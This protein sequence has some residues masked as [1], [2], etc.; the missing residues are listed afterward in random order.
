M[1]VGVDPVI[2]VGGVEAQEV[3]PLDEGDAP[4]VNEAAHVPDLDAEAVGDLGD[5]EQS[6]VL[7]VVAAAGS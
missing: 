4:F 1:T 7:R 3:P 5:G 6:L 2:D